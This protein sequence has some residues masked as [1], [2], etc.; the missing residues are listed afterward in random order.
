MRIAQWR[1]SCGDRPHT[2][3]PEPHDGKEHLLSATKEKIEYHNCILEDFLSQ[4]DEDI[5]EDPNVDYEMLL[6]GLR[7][8]EVSGSSTKRNGS[9]EVSKGSPKKERNPDQWKTSRTVLI[10]RKGDREDLRNY[11]PICLLSVLYKVITKIILTGISRTL[12]EAQPQEQVGFYQG[13]SCLDNIQ[14][15]SRVI[16]VCPEYRLPFVR[17]FVG[18]EK[19]FDSAETN[20][21]LSALADQSVDASY[22]RKLTN[23]YDRCTTKIL[24]FNRLLTIP[25]GK[26]LLNRGSFAVRISRTF[27]EHGKDLKEEL[28]RRMRE[29]WTAFTPVR[30]A[31]DRLTHKD[32]RAH[33]FDS[34]V[35]PAL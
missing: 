16:K 15:V 3:Q 1:D 12:D 11:R 22:V 35:L 8:E 32:L 21:I 5:E 23:C 26:G 34:T 7:A 10:H 30:E 24:L 27:Y 4:F 33:L 20:A 29:A 2:H 25:I 17:T 28:N 31:T 6:R 19:A 13:F 18:Y 14:T 9:I